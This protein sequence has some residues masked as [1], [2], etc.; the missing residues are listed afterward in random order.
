MSVHRRSSAIAELSVGPAEKVVDLP[1]RNAIANR[2]ERE[3]SIADTL[4]EHLSFEGDSPAFVE[5]FPAAA[6]ECQG[7][8][9]LRLRF[10]EPTVRK[11]H[12]RI[13]N[14]CL[15]GRLAKRLLE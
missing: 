15:D 3:F 2:S 8:G 10:I 12:T 4:G 6:V 1:I 5:R 9:D 11:E 14:V 13:R 7:F